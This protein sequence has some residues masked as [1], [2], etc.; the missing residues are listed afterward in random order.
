MFWLRIYN[1]QGSI[2][3]ND[4]PMSLYDA[5]LG[6]LLES[7][8]RLI[9]EGANVNAPRVHYALHVVGAK[10]H[11]LEMHQ[12]LERGAKACGYGAQYPFRAYSCLILRR[13]SMLLT[14][15]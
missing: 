15:K 13:H 6:G 2:E 4:N 11:D 1:P 8:I 7:A 9:S 12:L 10:T 14:A 3:A 5:S